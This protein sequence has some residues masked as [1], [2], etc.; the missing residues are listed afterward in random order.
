MARPKLV[1]VGVGQVRNKPGPD[2]PFEPIEP[3]RLAARAL[4]RAAADAG[5][6]DL[7]AA[8][9]FLGCTSPLAWHYD[10]FPD[11]LAQLLGI[12]PRERHQMPMGGETPVSLLNAAANRIQSGEVRV[13]LLAGAEAVYARRRARQEGVSLDHWTRAET[14]RDPFGGVRPMTNPLELRH[15]LALP[16]QLYPLFENALRARAGHSIDEHQVYV[17][18]LLA[19]FAAVAATNPYAWFPEARS[20]EEIRSV[21]DRNRWIFFPYTKFMNAIMEVDQAAACIALSE[22]EAERRGIR[23]ERRVTLLGGALGVDAWTAT[24][25]VDFVSSPAYRRAAARALELAQLD[26]ARV[27]L[28]DLYSCFPSAV[29]LA[30]GELGLRADDP[31]PLTVTGGLP[32][33]GGPG[34]NYAMHALARMVEKLRAGEGRVG[35]V[36]GLG[37]TA[38]KHAIAV[39]SNDPELSRSAAGSAEEVALPEAER[40]GPELADAPDGAGVVETYTVAFDRANRPERCIAIVRLEDGRRTVAHSEPTA[41]GLSRWVEAEGV[42]IRGKVVGGTDGAPNRFI[43][44]SVS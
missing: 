24:E 7:L 9:D 25:R 15:G 41:S 38:T 3:A 35:Y 21:T 40:R 19:R 12:E 22:D 27:D 17:S 26:L 29:E 5:D 36:S 34:N 4:E 14:R 6:R 18:E 31:R 32:Y 42:G 2:G 39:L 30:L 8:A 13:A 43:P 20:A 37:M 10:D 33:A 11:L 1:L 16:V 44:E 28:F 23:P